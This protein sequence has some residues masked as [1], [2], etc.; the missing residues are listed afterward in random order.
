MI[1]PKDTATATQRRPWNPLAILLVSL[2]CTPLPGGILHAL[3]YSRLGRPAQVR[4]TL[5]SNVL[6]A[7]IIVF[8]GYRS[9][10]MA[11]PDYQMKLLGLFLTVV[12]SIHFYRSQVRTF[13][14]QLAQGG[15][16][17]GW[18]TP[19][20]VGIVSACVLL[21]GDFGIQYMQLREF[22]RG[23]SLLEAKQYAEAEQIFERY[24]KDDPTMADAYYNLAIVYANSGRDQLA[25]Q[26]LQN[27]LKLS[28]FDGEARRF[29][30]SLKGRGDS[31]HANGNGT[32]DH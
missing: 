5:I 30:E 17:G 15:R 21:A 2:F 20:L 1:A 7:L 6:M 19:C 11:R 9:S 3:N 29:L 32:V 22:D 18:V 28:P 23:V 12:V 14:A 8:I 4:P 26:E 24:K 31:A 16:S 25:V 13:R 10:M 27:Y